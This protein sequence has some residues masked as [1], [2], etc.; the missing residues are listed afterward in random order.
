MPTRFSAIATAVISAF[1]LWL[2]SSPS[3]G[4]G[5]PGVTTL[6]ATNITSSSVRVTGQVN[7]N[8]V[9]TTAYFEV[10]PT[11]NYGSSTPIFSVGS[12]TSPAAANAN[13]SGLFSGTVYHY[14]VVAMNSFGTNFGL[15]ATFAT[16][17][18]LPISPTAVDTNV[19]APGHLVWL[20]QAA[21]SF[22]NLTNITAAEALLNLASSNS[23]VAFDAYDV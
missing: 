11:T 7:P 18:G 16:L 21:P 4:A 8:A 19:L 20:R 1:T 6:G 9:A 5:L 15:D 10:G 13:F 22:G 23:A 12:G 14:R 2:A 3:H 17:A